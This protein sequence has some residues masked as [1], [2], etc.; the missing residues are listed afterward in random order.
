MKELH[1]E[2]NILPLKYRREQHI[3]NHMYDQAQNLDSLRLR[4]AS[5]IRTR[6]HKKRMLKLKRP[7]TE[8]FKKSLAYAGPKRWNSLPIEFHQHPL[9]K[10]SFKAMTKLRATGA[11]DLSSQHNLVD[12]VI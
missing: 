12:L 9:P 6:L 3:L 11:A 8:K 1:Q 2:A 7:Y 10:K 5:T 4:P